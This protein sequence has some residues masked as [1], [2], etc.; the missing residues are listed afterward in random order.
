MGAILREIA[1]QLKDPNKKDPNKKVQLIYAFNGTGKTRLSQEFKNLIENNNS[2][3][4]NNNKYKILYYN[5]FTEDLFYWDNDLSNDNEYK[6]K[7][8][9]N[10]FIPWLIK[11]QGNEDKVIDKFHY[12]CDEKLM[13]KFDIK[14]NQITFSFARGDNTTE[15]N[16]HIS[17][18]EES[19]FIWSIFY[20]LIEQ[21][22]AE[23][24]ISEPDQ[25]STNKFDEL[26]YIFIDDPVSSLDE[27]HLVQLGVDLALLI[28]SSKS[29]LKFII[30]THNPLFYNILHNELANASKYILEKFEDNTY[31]L[32]SNQRDSPFAYHLFLKKEL[33]QAIET[34]QIR[35]YHFNCLRNI[36]EKTAIFLGYE[37][38]GDLL[39]KAVNNIDN[40]AKRE[41][42]YQKRII[43]LCSHSTI[44]QNEASIITDSDKNVLKKIVKFLNDTYHFKQCEQNEQSNE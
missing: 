33:E 35:K 40:S 29:G 17:R 25:R 24:N 20:T 44:S 6:L 1:Q 34:N 5:A 37:T 11:D 21:V 39:P 18:G 41:N 19:N 12:Y 14:N 22:V 38:W 10:F 23:L 42:T 36:L 28:K 7:I 31:Q 15:D 26:E 8:H 32:R 2:S 9:N 4:D 13:P 3:D 43:N 16:I 27:N 30:T